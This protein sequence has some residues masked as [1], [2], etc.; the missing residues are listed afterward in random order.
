MIGVAYGVVL[1]P[2]ASVS[3]A[4]VDLSHAIGAGREPLMLLGD[5]APPHVSVLHVDCADDRVPAIVA[6]AHP[7]R[8]RS[9]EV[10][11]TG[12]L[13]AVVPPG[14]YYVPSGGYYF[15][16]EV[17]R[18]PG[19]DALHREFLGLGMPPLGLVGEDYRPHI[20]LGV[21]ARPPV[22]PPLERVPTGSLR[23]TMASGPVGPYGT[24]PALSAV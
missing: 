10:T 8:E 5:E 2:E 12:L 13:Y 11:V 3:R 16:L 21:T 14:D 18:R 7:Y 20:T 19:L 9:F 15:G 22:L 4:L 1:V 6:A 23:M 24:F 17:I